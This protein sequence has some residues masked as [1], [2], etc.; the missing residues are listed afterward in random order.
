V[1][2]TS[3]RV[4]AVEI[5]CTL[6]GT[7][8]QPA[9][10]AYG[11]RDP[12]RERE[13]WFFD[14]IDAAQDH[15]RLLQAGIILR[16]R[17]E[18]DGSGESTVKLRP[19]QAEL[20]VRDFRAGTDRFGNSY[21]VEY[22]WAHDRVLAAS[23]NADVDRDAAARM[24]RLTEPIAHGYS[25]DQ[26]RLLNEAGTPPLAPFANLHRAGPIASERWNKVG[27]GPLKTL[28][29]E[30]WTYGD[31]K[32]FLELSLQAPDLTDADRLREALLKD[33]AVRGLQ[34]D[35]AGR[36]KTETVLRDLLDP[37]HTER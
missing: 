37:N 21:S 7:A 5:K 4:D 15:P 32:Q 8:L 13:I 25:A 30:R 18:N 22:D 35:P 9:M 11:L 34:P 27:D 19:A 16:L 14:S 29:A 3:T 20:L 1:I 31:D 26:L 2:V 17:R 33:L 36:S 24:V 23:M 28:R 12:D 10:A 6:S